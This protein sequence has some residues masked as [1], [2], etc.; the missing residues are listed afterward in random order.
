MDE[1]RGQRAPG[2]VVHPTDRETE[3][4]SMRG[5]ERE[6]WHSSSLTD[7]S[8]S[9]LRHGIP[10]ISLSLDIKMEEK[11]E[12]RVAEGTKAGTIA[13]SCARLIFTLSCFYLRQ[14]IA[15]TYLLTRTQ[16]MEK[17][18]EMMSCDSHLT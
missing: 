18:T 15:L 17:K 14:T 7:G 4:E 10:L 5:R 8:S 16:C 1:E 9:G 12:R 6:P 3:K 2:D 13:G 11:A